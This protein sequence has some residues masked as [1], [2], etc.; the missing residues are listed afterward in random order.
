MKAPPSNNTTAL[1]F[2]AGTCFPNS[3]DEDGLCDMYP[4]SFT[5]F[6]KRNCGCET[7]DQRIFKMSDQQGGNTISDIMYNQHGRKTVSGIFLSL[8]FLR[9]E[10][11]SVPK[12][13]HK[14]NLVNRQLDWSV[15]KN[16]PVSCEN[17]IVGEGDCFLSSSLDP[18]ILRDTGTVVCLKLQVQKKSRGR[19]GARVRPGGVGKGRKSRVQD[20]S[21]RSWNVIQFGCG[22][23]LV[24]TLGEY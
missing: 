14:R 2:F 22:K 7:R 1:G 23:S 6:E 4:S 9:D 18:K 19:E 21:A 12:A 20:P 11:L 5:F 10:N 13:A 17:N 15:Q 8:A 16:S 3:L 24:S